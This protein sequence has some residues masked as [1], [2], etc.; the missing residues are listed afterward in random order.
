MRTFIGTKL[1]SSNVSHPTKKPFEI[2]DSRL[3]GFILRVAHKELLPAL[4]TA[5]ERVSA[6][7]VIGFGGSV[8]RTQL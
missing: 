6:R 7:E 4:D 8:R 5:R 1:L 3:A 2:Y